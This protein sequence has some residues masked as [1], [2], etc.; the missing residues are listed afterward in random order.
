[1]LPLLGGPRYEAALVAGLL[2]PGW[3]AL[4]AALR[5]Q[6]RFRLE[7]ELRGTE[8]ISS[9]LLVA[10]GHVLAILLAALLSVLHNGLCEPWVGSQ[11][12]LL[13]PSV[14]VLLAALWGSGAGLLATRRRRR[15]V[16]PSTLRT[17]KLLG[18]VLALAGPFLSAA[19]SLLRFYESPAVYAF[20]HF[21]GYFAGPLYDTVTDD[22]SRLSLFRL[23]TASWLIAGGS[24]LASLRFTRSR[25]AGLLVTRDRTVLLGCAAL[26][27]LAALSLGERSGDWGLRTTQASLARALPHEV[28]EGP[29]VVQFGAGVPE[30]RARTLAHECVGHLVQIRRYF[31]LTGKSDQVRV[32]LF[33]NAD[34]KWWH[35]GARATYIAKPWRR[36]I[37]LQDAGFPHPVLGH[38]LAHVVAGEFGSGPFRIA[39]GLLGLLP[40]PGRIEGFAV[41]A[42]PSEQG[43]ATGAEWASAML[44]LGLLPRVRSL[45]SLGFLGNS[46]VRAYT[47][48]GAFIAWLHDTF[49]PEV[50]RRFYAGEDLERLTQ[51]DWRRLDE[52]F[53]GHLSKTHLPRGAL[54]LAEEVFSRPAVWGRRCPHAAA[55]KLGELGTACESAP[56]TVEPRLDE[57][58]RLD[59]TRQDERIMYPLCLLQHRLDEEGREASAPVLANDSVSQRAKAR[60]Q[61]ALAD[62]AWRSG[63]LEGAR[64]LSEE[65]LGGALTAAQRRAVQIKLWAMQ[66]S[67]RTQAAVQA[68]LS[69]GGT[70][71]EG[72]VRSSDFARFFQDERQPVLGYLWA[73]NIAEQDPGQS[74]DVLVDLPLERLPSTE[75][76]EEAYRRLLIVSCQIGDQERLARAQ[77][78][79]L[80][81]AK[82]GTT[83]LLAAQLPERC[84]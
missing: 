2:A 45:F 14:G 76:R 59:A 54:L 58:L 70:N 5:I 66:Q 21:V 46:A 56:Q 36:E 38:E 68:I 35:I 57:L 47:S 30:A 29:C 78:W 67:A 31:G 9:A 65:L 62:E 1:M 80:N 77:H 12:L 79:L 60:L 42:R 50:L 11:F 6:A 32:V 73:L 49:G 15:K 24:L 43:D 84:L 52:G 26:A 17:E 28:L 72:P 81:H 63:D 13:G 27:T 16:R 33:A 20:D 37:Y 23:I 64:K 61:L 22:L 82:L 41:A 55:R 39:G 48:A 40:D 7:G 3:A 19:V 83:R 34:E 44:E 75:L 8:V 25:A 10:G 71:Q 69:D 18:C 51:R 53:R 74:H 4:C